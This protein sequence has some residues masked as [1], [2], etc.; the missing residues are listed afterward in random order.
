MICPPLLTFSL[1]LPLMHTLHHSHLHLRLQHK[2]LTWTRCEIAHLVILHDSSIFPS[3]KILV[4]PVQPGCAPRCCPCSVP[5]NPSQPELPAG[6]VAYSTSEGH[7]FY[8]NQSRWANEEV[9]RMATHSPQL[10]T[11]VGWNSALSSRLCP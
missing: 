5:R 2:F 3:K 1:R 8:Y 10:G 11:C 9:A 6:W 4:S 7:V